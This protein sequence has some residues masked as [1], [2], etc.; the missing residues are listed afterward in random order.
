MVSAV[1]ALTRQS[2][3]WAKVG[4]KLAVTGLPVGYGFWRSLSLTKFGGMDRP[5]W[6]LETF[7]RHF[8]AADFPRKGGGF[9]LLELG[10]GDSLFTAPIARAHGAASVDLVDAGPFARLDLDLYRRMIAELAGQGYAVDD[11]AGLPTVDAVLE[12]CSARYGTHGLDSLRRVPT[13]SIDF[14]FSNAV[15][16]HVRRSEFQATLAELRRVMR[17]DGV[18]SHTIG[19]WDHFGDALN[20]LRFSERVWETRWVARSG[21]YTNRFRYSELL[22]LFAEAGFRAEVP[23]VNRWDRLPTPRDRM[24][25][26]FQRFDDDDLLVRSFNVLLRP[27]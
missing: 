16:Q 19:L 21:F 8:R 20:H 24:R 10:P 7:R 2:P 4:L 25:P 26:E 18:A 22:G 5:A 13:G 3:W 23:E 12:R 15:L 1:R 14:A 9:G 11:L 27:E 17:P 6:A